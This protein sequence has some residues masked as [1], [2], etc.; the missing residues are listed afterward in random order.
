MS[1]VYA[2]VDIEM[3]NSN[4]AIG[5]MIQFGCVFVQDDMIIGSYATD[6]NP[7]VTIDS[8]IQQLTGITNERVMKAPTF[9]EVANE[10]YE[11]L[12][13]C[14]FVAHNVSADYRFLNAEFERVGYELLSIPAVDTVELMQIFYPTQSSYQLIDLAKAFHFYHANPHQADSDAKVT[15]ELWIQLCKKIRQIPRLTLDRIIQ[16]GGQL[17]MQTRQFL[18][19]IR[20]T[21][22][23]Q[24][25]PQYQQVSGLIL[26]VPQTDV[27]AYHG[28]ETWQLQPQQEKMVNAIQAF[29]DSDTKNM[30]LEAPTASGKTL[31][32]LSAVHDVVTQKNPAII[33]TSSLVL[34]QQLLDESLPKL[35]ANRITPLHA[36][37][38][39]S[40]HHYLDLERFYQ[41]LMQRQL[42]QQERLLQMRVLVWLTETTTGDLDEL[43]LNADQL[44]HMEQYV[45]RGIHTL[46]EDSPFYKWDFLR[47]RYQM[48][49]KAEIIITNHAFLIEETLR[50]KPLLPETNYLIIDEAHQ[51]AQTFAKS[52]EIRLNASQIQRFIKKIRHQLSI[53]EHPA[54]SA[55]MMQFDYDSLEY[56]QYICQWD[57]CMKKRYCNEKHWHHQPQFKEMTRQEH[58]VRQKLQ[59]LTTELTKTIQYLLQK[60]TDEDL[61]MSLRQFQLIVDY[62][63]LF[64]TGKVAQT[65]CE[66]A[67]DGAEVWYQLFDQ[68]QRMIEKQT[69][70]RRARHILYVGA[71]LLLDGDA[72]YFKQQLQLADITSY[73][74][75]H[76]FDYTKQA[77]FYV[78]DDQR[79][80]ERWYDETQ[81]AIL[82]KQLMRCDSQKVMALFT[83]HQ[84]LEK[85]YEL[86]RDILPAEGI[87]LLA[88][89]LTGSKVRNVKQFKKASYALMLGTVSYAEGLDLP[90][91]Y[92]QIL[93]MNKLPFASPDDDFQQY[94]TAY[95]REQ[96]KD[97]F[98]D[99][100]LPQAMIRLKQSVGRLIR[101]P[102]DKGVI[103]MLDRRMVDAPYAKQMQGNLPP[104]LT[105]QTAQMS[106]IIDKIQTFFA[107]R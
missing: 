31:A 55:K 94:M 52:A 103:L 66:M 104:G 12:Q 36:V 53:I 34:E 1:Q 51:F 6:V 15:A 5:R 73:Q 65:F 60:L 3:T 67:Y 86:L 16:C 70:Y 44:A 93:V 24:Q 54:F 98:Y 50:D 61:S 64:L 100:T 27:E 79:D 91:D 20:K 77:R 40:A 75:Q 28:D 83:S 33:S 87:T 14:V 7:E 74:V 47:R 99:Y 17:T 49:E 9:F 105:V 23:I 22:P 11:M 62:F 63:S 26:K 37:L 72:S 42:G 106:N 32:Y 25:N 4:I 8:K 18:R 95:S 84:S 29:F 80:D 45:H 56:G 102:N 10:I 13:N 76:T 46:Y 19:R 69:W 57:E 43:Q 48:L 58:Q 78:L 89:N 82:L 81:T 101:T 38:M 90:G 41:S 88:Q 85:V 2:V 96:G 107:E 92:L 21:L 97:P 30:A 39:K 35:N 59:Q 68:S 71:T